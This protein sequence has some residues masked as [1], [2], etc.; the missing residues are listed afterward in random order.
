MKL[1]VKWSSNTSTANLM[2]IRRDEVGR[3]VRFSAVHMITPGLAHELDRETLLRI[4]D[5]LL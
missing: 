4:V 3:R 1:S 2:G 5:E